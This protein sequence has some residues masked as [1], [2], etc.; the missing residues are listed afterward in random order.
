MLKLICSVC[1]KKLVSKVRDP[2]KECLLL[3]DNTSYCN[4]YDKTRVVE[5][6][7]GTSTY[8]EETVGL[9]VE[10]AITIFSQM[11]THRMK[12]FIDKLEQPPGSKTLIGMGMYG[13]EAAQEQWKVN[14]LLPKLKTIKKEFEEIE[15]ILSE[16]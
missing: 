15:Q 12:L 14:K 1:G 16:H 13:V 10:S 8:H 4:N 9:T 5:H 6:H 2:E 11:A 7:T 3:P